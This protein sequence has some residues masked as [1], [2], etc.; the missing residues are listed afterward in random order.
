MP[1]G[2]ATSKPVTVNYF[3]LETYLDMVKCLDGAYAL[4]YI[5]TISS[6]TDIDGNKSYE[7][8]L[9]S[10]AQTAIKAK[11]GDV[12]TWNGTIMDVM[13]LTTFTER[14]TVT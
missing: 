4:G 1:L 14:Y 7:M 13:P 9:K 2:H 5:G 8:M 3:H 11:L 10:K 12:F 6:A